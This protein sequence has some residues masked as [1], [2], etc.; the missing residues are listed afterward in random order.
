MAGGRRAVRQ[1]DLRQ[2]PLGPRRPVFKTPPRRRRERWAGQR[3]TVPAH[4]KRARRPALKR[5]VEQV[6]GA[7]GEV[8]AETVVGLGG[9]RLQWQERVARERRLHVASAWKMWAG[10]GRS[11]TQKIQDQL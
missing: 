7:L 8:Q 5:E 3:Q 11:G 10:I 1:A 9:Q 2:S 6:T 4:S